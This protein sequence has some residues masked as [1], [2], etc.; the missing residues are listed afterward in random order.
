MRTLSILGSTGSIGRQTLEIVDMFPNHF[1]V[2]ALCARQNSQL[3]FE[4][5]RR[6]QPKYAALT[7]CEVTI[8][9]DLKKSCEWLFGDAALETLAGVGTAQD[10]MVS[11]SGMVGLR[12]VLAARQAGR[13]VLLA[14]KEALVAGGSLVMSQCEVGGHQATLLPVDSEHSAIFQCLN[15]SQGNPFRK[16]ILT[17][18]G[19]PFRNW[20]IKKIK[21]ATIEQALNHPNWSM[22]SK[23]SID[24]ASMFNKALEII[25]AKWLFSADPEQIEVVVHPQSIVH[26]CVEFE[27][28]TVLAQ[29][30]LPDMR[31]PILYAMNYPT[32]LKTQMKTLDLTAIKDLSFEAPDLERFPA[33][34]LAYQTLQT[35]DASSCILNAANEE[36][37]AMFLKDEIKFGQIYY[38]VENTL[39]RLGSQRADTLEEVEYADAIARRTAKRMI[40]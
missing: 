13:R 1:K 28:G 40:Q 7:G 23:I 38:I 11:V 2:E 25:E 14:N 30:G 20:D 22:G 18:S 4:Q 32:R 31:L 8:P 12:A 24:S 16:L 5:V 21:T 9:K 33:I 35:N 6:Y 17:A 10:V 27:D 26:S 29:M 34:S 19:G 37:V 36:A 39:Q 15:A 3:L